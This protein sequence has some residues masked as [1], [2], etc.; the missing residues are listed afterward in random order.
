MASIAQAETG[1]KRGGGWFGQSYV[2][3]HVPPDDPD[4]PYTIT[5]RGLFAL[6]YHMRHGDTMGPCPEPE[7]RTAV[8]FVGHGEPSTATDGD[9]PIT[10]PDGEPFGPHAASLGVPESAQYT[11]W[12]AAYEEI[13]TAMSYIFGDI[14]GNGILHEVAIYPDGDVPD[15]FV[16]PAFHGTVYQQYQACNY[17]SP[18]NDSIREHVES[19]D[20]EVCAGEADIFLA[21]LDAVP[22]IRDVLWEIDQAGGYDELVVI[23]MLLAD[24]THTQEVHDLLEEAAHLTDGMEVIVGEP[25]FEVPFMQRRFRDGVLGIAHHLRA[26]VPGDVPDYNI[27]VV[28]A[29]HGTPYVPPHPEFHRAHELLKPDH[30]RCAGSLRGRRIHPCHGGSVRIPHRR[31]SHHVGCG[32]RGRRASRPAAGR[33]GPSHPGFGHD[34]LLLV[35]G[36]RRPRARA[37]GVPRGARVPRRERRDGGY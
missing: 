26:A 32:Q 3:C 1:E 25:F 22:R 16:W 23:P 14:N 7:G 35:A 37:H 27:G 11:E 33:G 31:H 21:F 24:S 15:F 17:Y 29:S 2:I 9:I 6:W 20:I 36:L 19:L 5:V 13:A 8:L 28:L 18:H 12:A 10:F 30:R 4:N 34:G